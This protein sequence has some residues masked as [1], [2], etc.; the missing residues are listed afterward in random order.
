MGSSKKCHQIFCFQYVAAHVGVGLASSQIHIA[1]VDRSR[2]RANKR[3]NVN[4]V[5][6]FTERL[7]RG[8]GIERTN[9]MQFG[10]KCRQDVFQLVLQAKLD[11]LLT[12][13]A[14]RSR[15]S[16]AG[17]RWYERPR[18]VRNFV[19]FGELTLQ[20]GYVASVCG[21]VDVGNVC[22]ERPRNRSVE[23]TEPGRVREHQSLRLTERNW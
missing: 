18:T 9:V 21:V 3:S 20:H 23:S 2:A 5:T 10:W 22:F 6:S 7:S 1:E 17:D 11:E 13:N 4:D 15:I 19:A 14:Q 16:D 8:H 12:R